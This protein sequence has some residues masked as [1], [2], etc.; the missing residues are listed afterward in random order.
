MFNLLENGNNIAVS[1]VNQSVSNGRIG[2]PNVN[3]STHNCNKIYRYALDLTSIP[4][5]L[6]ARK[7]K[8]LLR[9]K[10]FRIH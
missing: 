10:Y 6:K 8:Q 4:N 9:L 5:K 7:M 3:N 2:V 1:M